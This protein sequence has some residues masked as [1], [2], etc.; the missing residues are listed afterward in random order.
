MNKQLTPAENKFPVWNKQNPDESLTRIYDW[1]VLRASENIA[2]YERKKKPRRIWSK[3]LRGLSIILAAVGALCPLIDSTG[4]LG[5]QQI[6]DAQNRLIL[7]QWGYVFLAVAASLAGF[8]YYFGHSSAWMRFIVTQISMERALKEF[9]YDWVL[10]KVQQENNPSNAPVLMQRAKDFTLQIENITK[11]E[12]DAWVAE[13]Q[14]N[15]TQLEKVLKTETE[16]RKQGSVKISVENA[17]E[18]EEVDV[19]LNGNSIKQLDGVS[20]GIINNITCG[21]HEITVV[22]KKDGK[23]TKSN[24]IIEVQAGAMTTAEFNL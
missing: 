22:G 8:D 10:L 24:K 19:Y 9:Q 5:G 4:I 16:A 1:A 12:T 23:Q 6:G 11:Q 18:F 17:P 3:G 15:I 20:E 14:T 2:W 13:F 7:A 21:S